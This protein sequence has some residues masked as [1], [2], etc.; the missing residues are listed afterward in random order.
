LK[1]FT[2]LAPGTLTELGDQVSSRLAEIDHRPTA[3]RP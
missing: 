3:A 1:G 2:T